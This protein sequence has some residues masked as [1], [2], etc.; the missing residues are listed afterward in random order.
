MNQKLNIALFSPNKNPYSETFIQAHKNNLKGNVYFYYGIG[1]DIS[2]E[3]HPSLSSK[4]KKY[5]LKAIKIIFKKN[6]S[7]VLV[8]L[9]SKSLKKQNIDVVLVEYG[10]HANHILPAIIKVNLPL[11]VHFHGFDATVKNIIKENKNYKEVFK[12]ASKI[13]VVSKVMKQQLLDI[14]CPMG[15]LV[16]NANAAQSKFFTIEPNFNSKQFISVGRFNNKKAPYYTILSFKEALKKHSDAKLLLCGD[17]LLFE[18]CK[19][20]VR[21]YQLEKNIK[22]LGVVS[23][24]KLSELL[25]NSLGYVQHS[26]TAENGDTEGMPISILEASASGIPVISTF[27]AGISDVVKDGVSGLLCKEHDVHK[28]GQNII[29]ILDDVDYAKKLGQAGKER[30][31]SQFSF[32]KHINGIQQLLETSVKE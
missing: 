20:L 26:I 2:L 15:K 22:F 25:E 17:G 31:K 21:H 27:H 10:I 12:Y 28:M 5:F 9:L 32:E 11:V 29:K 4:L 1:E 8:K 19:N 30:I 13:I 14:G 3:N 7:F 18:V 16:Y 23:P 6:H 24:E